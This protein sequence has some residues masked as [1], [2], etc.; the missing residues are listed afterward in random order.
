MA[1]LLLNESVLQ[2]DEPLDASIWC[3]IFWHAS[4]THPV[5][6]TARAGHQDERGR[7]GARP[8]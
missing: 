2:R 3:S 5:T 1:M 8:R 6:L 4:E 7:G